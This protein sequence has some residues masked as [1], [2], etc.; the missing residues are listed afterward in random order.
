MSPSVGTTSVV[1]SLVVFIALYGVLAVVGW[2]LMARFARRE[3]AEEPA[4]ETREETREPE[5]SY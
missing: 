3:L 2:G 4:P 5:P 1:V